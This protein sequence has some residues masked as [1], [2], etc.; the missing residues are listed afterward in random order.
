MNIRRLKK[1]R[2]QDLPAI[3][4]AAVGTRTKGKI[5]YDLFD[6]QLKQKLPGYRVVWAYA[7]EIVREKTGH[8]G[9]FEALATLEAEGYRK[10]VVQPLYLFAG[11]EYKELV[12]DCLSFPG[13]RVLVGETLA[14]RWPFVEEVLA[15]LSQ[16]F[17]SSN[18]GANLL[19]IHGT[20]HCVDPA[21]IVYV[22]LD[23]LLSQTFEN[24]I[25]AS[26]EGIP[27][28]KGFFNK[29]SKVIKDI[30]E[31][32]RIIPFLYASGVHVQEDLFGDG[33]SFKTRLMT[34]GYECDCLFVQH[35]GY[36][37]PKSLGF[38]E[39]VQLFFIDRVKMAI[40]LIAYY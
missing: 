18:E 9:V 30:P 22:G 36:R 7:S 6:S 24:V 31:K 10:V 2:F 40:D 11:T 28:Q 4:I 32:V 3:V 38:Y 13:L 23:Y 5:V 37:F 35:N 14:H 20:P 15:V 21:N 26:L 19:I 25:L 33:N 27:G 29:L 34:L 12:K 16:D 39:A 17:L 1:R 8:P